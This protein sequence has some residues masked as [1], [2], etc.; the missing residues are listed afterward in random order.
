MPIAHIQSELCCGH[1]ILLCTPCH[2]FHY[3]EGRGAPF[4]C[5][6]EF[7][8]ADK[9]D[10]LYTR[11]C[12]NDKVNLVHSYFQLCTLVLPTMVIRTSNNG[13]SYFQQWSFVLPTIYI[14]ISNSGWPYFQICTFVF[15]IVVAHISNCG[16]THHQLRLH[17]SA[18]AA[19]DICIY[20]C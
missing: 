15:P 12:I 9:I 10:I 11:S 18:F 14:R 13:H 5:C 20:G 6:A 4:S 2:V 16:S 17:T 3:A 19:A 1:R 8:V 7:L